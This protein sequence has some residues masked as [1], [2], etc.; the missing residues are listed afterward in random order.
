MVRFIAIHGGNITT[1]LFI[2][3]HKDDYSNVC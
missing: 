2:L 3:N 1:P